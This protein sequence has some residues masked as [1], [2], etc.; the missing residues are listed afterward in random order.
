MWYRFLFKSVQNYVLS[1]R[2]KGSVYSPSNDSIS[3]SLDEYSNLLKLLIADPIDIF[4][5]SKFFKKIDFLL[6]DLIKGL[7][8][9]NRF[10]RLNNSFMSCI[11]DLSCILLSTQT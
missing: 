3:S 11:Q 7:I 1:N 5:D 2:S 8:L 6:V 10:N 9:I 4:M